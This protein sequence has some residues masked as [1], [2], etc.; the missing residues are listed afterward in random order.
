M[1]CGFAHS[2]IGV[3]SQTSS[4]K[5]HER[6]TYEMEYF[7]N[8]SEDGQP[9]SFFQPPNASDPAYWWVVAGVASYSTQ[10][11][12]LMAQVI[13]PTPPVCGG[14]GVLGTSL[15]SID[16]VAD[17]PLDWTYH[18][19]ELPN[20][21]ACTNWFVG[22]THSDG[23]DSDL[24]YIIGTNG[25]QSY[26]ANGCA[27]CSNS[28]VVLARA[29]ITDLRRL[30]WGT[31]VEFWCESAAPTKSSLSGKKSG[32][33]E[34]SKTCPNA[35]LR[36][37]FTPTDCGAPNCA[38]S[39]MSLFYNF[40]LGRW[41][42]FA[43]QGFGPDINFWFSESNDVTSSWASQTVYVST[44]LP[45][46]IASAALFLSTVSFDVHFLPPFPA[47]SFTIG[48]PQSDPGFFSYAA[49]AHPGLQLLGDELVFSFATNTFNISTLADEGLASIYTPQLV[50]VQ[51]AYASSLVIILISALLSVF[52]LAATTIAIVFVVQLRQRWT[53]KTAK[54]AYSPL[55]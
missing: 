35:Q 43:V 25:E 18:S 53:N 38:I 15:I 13:V 27:V 46:A 28:S 9:V 37:L 42:A 23:K 2:T 7:V 17:P 40:Y 1:S 11:I 20:T 5:K 55:N 50:S 32:D 22:M 39:E 31:E 41:Y 26:D 16:N 3:L 36:P 10:D 12:V 49:K 45:I 21:N 34:W 51:V 54:S 47:F 19:L 24:A 6:V 52:V 29:N 48:K 14:F 8:R 4:E 33:G 44:H 30:R